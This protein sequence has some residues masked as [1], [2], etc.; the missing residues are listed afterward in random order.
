MK[1]RDIFI[2]IASMTLIFGAIGCC[3]LSNSE[4]M[5]RYDAFNHVA[6]ANLRLRVNLVEGAIIKSPSVILLIDTFGDFVKM[7]EELNATTVYRESVY[8]RGS[9]DSYYVFN[10]QMTIAY[11]YDLKL[12]GS[13]FP[14]FVDD[15]KIK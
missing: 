10:E 4:L 6:K 3:Y 15:L 7:V 14:P 2:F 1:N 9:W 11:R 8:F 5:R 12:T 13:F